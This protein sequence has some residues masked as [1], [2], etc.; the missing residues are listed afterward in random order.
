MVNSKDIISDPSGF[1]TIKNK[2]TPEELSKHY[3]NY[4]KTGAK[5]PKN[6]QES[7]DSKEL[8]FIRLL[9]DLCLHAISKARPD[10]KKSGTMLDVGVGEGFMMA[11]ALSKGWRVHGIDFSNYAAK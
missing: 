11:R 5:R 2:P 9:N 8:K 6:Y 10:W 7:Y 4:L 3:N 1:K